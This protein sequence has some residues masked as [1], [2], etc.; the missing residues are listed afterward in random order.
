MKI[1]VGIDDTDTLDTPG[2]NHLARLIASR[3]PDGFH[4]EAILRHQLF[5]DPR[6]P[7]TS[8]NGSASFRIVAPEG[9][10]AI[11]TLA[12]CFRREMRA[13]FVPGSDPGLCMVLNNVPEAVRAFGRLCQRD[14]VRQAQARELA[15]TEG[16][17][18]EGLGGTE[19]G[20]IGSLAAVGLAATRDDGRVI[21]LAGWSFT[22]PKTGVLDAAEI[23]SL[24]VD[25]I[26]EKANSRAV[27]SGRVELRKKLRPNVTE[28]KIVLF[29]EPGELAEWRALKVT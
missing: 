23:L 27:V 20:V 15:A 10:G 13:W 24:G 9:D 4:C 2:T 16:I 29:V 17:L 12:E 18:L 25:E 3:L 5:F 14:V 26:R 8:H 21:H 19:D 28:G 11:G 6:V 7:Y 1:F 22:D